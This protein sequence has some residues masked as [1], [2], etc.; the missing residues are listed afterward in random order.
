MKKD[1]WD[2]ET[3]YWKMPKGT[4]AIAD[5]GYVGIK[6]KVIIYRQEHS[7]AFKKFMGRAKNR[8]KTLRTRI[9][10]FNA[11]KTRFRHGRGT[12]S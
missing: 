7:A 12:K 9:K 1:D 8:Q 5:S 3:L 4:K 11:L 2:H 10:S 6:D